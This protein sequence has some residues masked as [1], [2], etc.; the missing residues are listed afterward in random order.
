M[1]CVILA[2]GLG[3]RLRPFTD[4]KPKCLVELAGKSLLSW[5]LSSLNEAGIYNINVVVG[6]KF[7][8]IINLRDSRINQ[9][10]LNESY[11]QNNMVKSLLL[12]KKLFSSSLL[13]SYSDIVYSSE[14]VSQLLKFEYENSI[15]VDVDWLKLWS[16]RFLNPLDDAETLQFN[17]NFDLVDIG[18]KPKKIEEIMAQYIGLMKFSRETLNV[19]KH[20]DL[21]NRISDNLYMTDLI[22]ML[23][24]YKIKIKVIPIYRG[25]LE[26]DSINDLKIYKNE[27]KKNKSMTIYS[28]FR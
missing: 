26:V 16:K 22:R 21:K 10:F 17:E 6:H 7:K 27:L 8:E 15:I 13:I 24:K 28:I 4:N 20:L 18:Q 9:I 19:I 23:L 1:N 25:W 14:V 5:Q 11:R 12:S 3:N 2:A